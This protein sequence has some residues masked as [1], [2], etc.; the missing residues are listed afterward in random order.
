MF[1]IADLTDLKLIRIEESTNVYALAE[2]RKLTHTSPPNR[3]CFI[4]YITIRATAGSFEVTELEIDDEAILRAKAGS[5]T[6]VQAFFQSSHVFAPAI[7]TTFPLMMIPFRRTIEIT[8]ENT[9][10]AGNAVWSVWAYVHRDTE[11]EF[12]TVASL[13]GG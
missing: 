1:N 11:Q 4:A 13:Q 2:T 12:Q 9:L 6:G 7:N 8:L 5:S 3:L 10:A